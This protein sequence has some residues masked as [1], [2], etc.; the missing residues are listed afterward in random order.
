MTDD[1]T[2]E[3]DPRAASPP[4]GTERWKQET[5]GIERVI[6]V[7]LALTEPRTA[8]WVADEALVS[9]QTAREHLDLLTELGVVA[10]TT[11]RGVTKYRPDATWLRFQEVAALVEKHSRDEL[12][13]RVES[14]KERIAETEDSYGVEGPDALRS[15][16]A[17]DGT[18]VE[19]VREYRQAAAEWETLRHELDLLE[20]ALERYDEYDRAATTA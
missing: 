18:G 16:A 17:A 10:A 8:G 20:E 13:D 19:E 1:G 6:D 12:L 15:R 2:S 4:R 11:A 7:A 3:G 14:Y 5:K 9:E